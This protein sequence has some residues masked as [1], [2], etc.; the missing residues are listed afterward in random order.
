MGV[1][2]RVTHKRLR[3]K[4]SL[5]IYLDLFVDSWSLATLVDIA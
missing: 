3:A 2:P 1:A 4:Q 5:F